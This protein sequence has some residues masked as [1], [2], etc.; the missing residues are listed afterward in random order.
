MKFIFKFE[1][2]IT[3]KYFLKEEFRLTPVSVPLQG[4]IQSLNSGFKQHELIQQRTNRDSSQSR[5]HTFLRK[6]LI[7]GVVQQVPPAFSLCYTGSFGHSPWYKCFSMDFLL[8]N[9]IPICLYK[10]EFRGMGHKGW[11]KPQAF[12][13]SP[14]LIPAGGSQ[15]TS[16][17]DH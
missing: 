16:G 12:C 3:F 5:P 1:L 6:S 11:E 7:P 4:C 10:C 9:S 14:S 2:A 17:F 15:M 8:G 13:C